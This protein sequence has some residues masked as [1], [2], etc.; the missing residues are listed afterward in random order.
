M[1]E[2]PDLSSFL[3]HVSLVMEAET[4]NVLKIAFLIMTLH[5]AKG[6]EFETVFCRAGKRGFF[7]TK[8]RSTS[9]AGPGSRKN[10][11]S[12]MSA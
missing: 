7:R 4:K 6:L 1:E 10:A 9:R 11:A 2:F 3:E 12:P 5:A 8:D